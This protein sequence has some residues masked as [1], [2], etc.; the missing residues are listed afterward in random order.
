[1]SNRTSYRIFPL[2]RVKYYAR[3]EMFQLSPFR[4]SMPTSWWTEMHALNALKHVMRDDILPEEFPFK[5]MLKDDINK[6]RFDTITYRPM[7]SLN[8]D[9]EIINF[10]NAPTNANEVK[11]PNPEMPVVVQFT[12]EVEPSTQHVW[13]PIF[14]MCMFQRAHMA[15]GAPPMPPPPPPSV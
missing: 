15:D 14:L 3:S 6:I 7:G 12:Y 4:C 9:V 11:L 8:D 1:M 10:A 13:D 5:E 2:G